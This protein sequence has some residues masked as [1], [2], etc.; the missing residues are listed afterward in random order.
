MITVKNLNFYSK[1]SLKDVE[2]RILITADFPQEFHANY[3]MT[4]PFLYVTL[5]VRGGVMVKILDE[6]TVKLYT[7]TR[8]EFDE[9]SYTEIIQFAKKHSKQFN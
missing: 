6:G 5:Y 7:P 1:L 3:R 8:K 9:K 4:Q 2:D